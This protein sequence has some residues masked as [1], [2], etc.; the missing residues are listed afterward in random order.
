MPN[1]P[2]PNRVRAAAKNDCPGVVT[3][4]LKPLTELTNDD[5]PGGC[6]SAAWLT[7]AAWAARPC[8]VVVR[9]GWVN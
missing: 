9:G 4:V 1:C 2:Q 7:A 5:Q 6:E 3:T 8:A